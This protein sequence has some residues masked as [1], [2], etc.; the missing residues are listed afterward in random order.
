MMWYPELMTLLR[1]L[2]HVA[3]IMLV[4]S[5]TAMLLLSIHSQVAALNAVIFFSVAAGLAWGASGKNKRA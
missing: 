3:A 2:S 4:V 1:I 5:G